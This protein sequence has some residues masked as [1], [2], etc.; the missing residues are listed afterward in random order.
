MQKIEVK[1]KECCLDCDHFDVSGIRGV[2]PYQNYGCGEPDRVIAC[3]HMVVCGRYNDNHE[4]SDGF[5][6]RCKDCA[7]CTKENGKDFCR[8][9]AEY[10]YEKYFCGSAE[11]KKA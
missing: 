11:H 5:I 10:V 7:N 9:H 1:L 3:G 2:S 6:I 8:I 4:N